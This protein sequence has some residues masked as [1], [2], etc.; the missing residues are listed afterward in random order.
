[1]AI[2]KSSKNNKKAELEIGLAI[3]LRVCLC[4]RLCE[5]KAAQW[6]WPQQKYKTGATHHYALR[7]AFELHWAAVWL[8]GWL[9]DRLAICFECYARCSRRLVLG[10]RKEALHRTFTY[11][12]AR[13]TN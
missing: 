11:N 8:A 6:L 13:G 2:T 4:L 5:K 7:A 1:M 10:S 12:S 3:E 9:A